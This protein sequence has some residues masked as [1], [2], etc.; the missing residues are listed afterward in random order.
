MIYLDNAATTYPKPFAVTKAVGDA[1]VRYGANPGRGGHR[2]AMASAEQVYACREEIAAFFGLSDPAGVVFTANCTVALNTVIKGL[3]RDGGH[4]VVSVYEHNA[5]IRPLHAL[6][7]VTYTEV[8]CYPDSPS[9]TVHGF[10]RAVRPD[11]RLIVCAH[12]SFVLGVRMP[13]REIGEMAQRRG[14][15]F[16]VDA[17]QS[18][19][20]LPIDMQRDHIDFL[21]AP[22]HKALYGPMGTGILLC[23]GEVL[24]LPLTEGGTGNLSLLA[25]QP[26]ELPER[27]ESGTLNV[28]GICG[29]LAGVRFVRQQGVE[30]LAA[31]EAACMQRL[32][33]ALAQLPQVDLYTRYPDAQ[34]A[35]PMVTFNVRGCPSEHI[36]ERLSEVHI[37]V[38]A[39]LHCAPSAHRQMGTV[40]QGAVRVCPSAFTTMQNVDF[41]VKILHEIARNPLQSSQ[42][43]IK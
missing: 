38:R 15:P 14:I 22:G 19:G 39:G 17:A 9:E 4:V 31:R 10:E 1:L 16:A 36:A 2:M 28:P 13:I 42:S 33:A 30:A 35:V 6:P 26:P 11:T 8:P 34:T 32:Y 40:E 37:A 41:T 12:A 20:L 18:A 43:M 25:E 23:G 27:L 5:V 21:C 3:L 24:P 7:Q 29:L